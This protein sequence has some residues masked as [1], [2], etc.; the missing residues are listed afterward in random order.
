MR[1]PKKLKAR[2]EWGMNTKSVHC[3]DLHGLFEDTVATPIFQTSTFVF[4]DTEDIADYTSKKRFR[5]EY[6]RYGN[7]TQLVAERKL[8]ELEG[9]EDCLIFDCGMSAV[10]TTLLAFLSQGEHIICTDDAYKKNLEFCVG[11]LKRFGVDCTVVK[12]GDTDAFETAIQKNTRIIFSESP[13]NPYLRI[14]DFGK[15][16]RMKKK[17]PHVLQI[18]D[19]TF[20]TPYN[21]L[22]LEYGVDLVIHSGTK[23]FAG[24]NDVL[25][26]MVLGSREMVDKVRA[27]QKTVGGI[28]DPY[29][30]F[31]LIRGLKTFA[32]RVKHQNESAQKLA[33]WLEKHPKVRKTWYPGLK[34]HPDHSIAKK[35]MKGFGGVVTFEIDAK[36]PGVKRFLNNLNL[37][38]MGPS[39]GGTEALLSHISSMTY[40]MIPREKRIAM[41]IIDELVR[42]AVGLEDWQ[43]IAADLDHALSKV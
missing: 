43:D 12:A 9:A 2:A 29:G 25:A 24:H 32:L 13:T 21:Q 30:V 1:N 26:G 14:V 10:T 33:E 7:P 3:G 34:S 27:M 42:L 35:Q 8:M 15:L 4:H 31:L 37:C 28:L 19:G 11:D 40:Y 17:H 41:G 38:Q 16:R 36:M 39:L 23:Y 18:I 22:P 20:G 5:Y 6:G